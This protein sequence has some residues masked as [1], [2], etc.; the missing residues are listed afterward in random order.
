MANEHLPKRKE[1]TTTART[2][3]LIRTKSTTSLMNGMI[4]A[5]KDQETKVIIYL[6]YE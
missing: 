1:H 4:S 2:E 6:L 3:M 5:T